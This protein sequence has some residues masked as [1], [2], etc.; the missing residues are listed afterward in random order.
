V[1]ERSRHRKAATLTL[2]ILTTLAV[3]QPQIGDRLTQAASSED[4]IAS[5]PFAN[6]SDIQMIVMRMSA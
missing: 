3:P 6:D 5:P 1:G 4:H 2:D